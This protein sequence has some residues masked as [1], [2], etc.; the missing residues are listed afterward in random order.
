MDTKTIASALAG[1]MLG[2][3]LVSVAAEVDEP[4]VPD[5]AEITTTTH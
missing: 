2:G 5:H 3:L 4:A 1:F